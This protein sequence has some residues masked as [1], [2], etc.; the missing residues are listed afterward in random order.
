MIIDY[1][2][3][4]E[5][6]VKIKNNSGKEIKI[7]C[8]SWLSNFVVGDLMGRNPLVTI[9][10]SVLEHVDILYIS[11]AHS[12]HLDPYTLIQLYKN[13]KDKPLLVIPE[14]LLYLKDLFETYLETK[15]IILRNKDVFE[16][17]GIKLRGY[18]FE[19]LEVTNEDDVMSLFISNEKEI[20][21]TEVDSLPPE[22]EET[23]NYIYRIF[24]EKKY[25][26]ILYLA[27]RNELE[28]NLKLLDISDISQRKKFA[29][30]YEEIRK[31]EIEYSYAKFSE[32]LVDFK[33]VSQLKGFMRIYIG[34]WICYP[35]EVDKSFMNLRLMTLENNVSLDMFYSRQY[36][37]KFFIGSFEAGKSY[38]IDNGKVISQRLIEYLSSLRFE[39]PKVQLETKAERKYFR[40]PMAN[41][42]RDT[43]QQTEIFLK[44]LNERFLPYR[45]WVSG[46]NLKNSML[47][48]WKYTIKIKFWTQEDFVEKYFITSFWSFQFSLYDGKNIYYD[49]DYW[50]N[51]IEDFYNGTQELYSNFHHSLEKGKSYRF[52]TS[53]WA[54]FLNNDLVLKKFKF[55][56]QRASEWKTADD[57]V[58]PIYKKLLWEK[59]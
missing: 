54:T 3:H 23:W 18:I 2:W 49:E 27:T 12:D 59:K 7:L 5:F 53:L 55:H 56:F 51:D 39:N 10:Y 48:S 50:A 33:D 40:W 32:N 52:W 9:N 24:T 14:T 19:N 42:K 29:K 35:L 46:D 1:F 45:L 47:K 11:H 58:L 17:E 21:Y 26:T 57:F 34:Q 6:L 4:S 31:E 44:L 22:T 15:V 25:E 13:L 8:D 38:V 41:E 37:K 36:Q 28:W 43:Q 20:L 16:F 30:E